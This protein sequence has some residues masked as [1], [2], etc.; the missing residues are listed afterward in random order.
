MFES[1]QL[2]ISC[3]PTQFPGQLRNLLVRLKG[4][5]LAVLVVKDSKSPTRHGSS[6]SNHSVFKHA[7]DVNFV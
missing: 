2:N 1:I 3:L 7:I 5:T 4:A 6:V